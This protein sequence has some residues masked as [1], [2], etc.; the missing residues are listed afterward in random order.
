MFDG[1]LFEI[2]GQGG[3]AGGG[4]VARQ[5]ITVRVLNPGSAECGVRSAEWGT[6]RD[7]ALA[8]D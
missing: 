7:D 3:L 6:E 5:N 4:G 8:A 2:V 1:G